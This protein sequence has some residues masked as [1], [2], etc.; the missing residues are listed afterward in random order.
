[1]MIQLL[2][3]QGT[4]L[5]EWRH[6][7][8]DAQLTGRTSLKGNIKT[9]EVLWSHYVGSR[10]TLLEVQFDNSGVKVIDLPDQDIMKYPQFD[11]L[12]K[13]NGI[14]AD[15]D[16]DGIQ[17]QIGSDVGDVLP[18]RPGLERILVESNVNKEGPAIA[19]LYGR[20]NHNWI[21]LWKRPQSPDEN[22]TEGLVAAPIPI[23]GDFDGDGRNEIA[24]QGWYWMYIVDAETGKLKDK[25][26]FII[27]GQAESGRGYGWFGAHDFNGDGK[28]EFVII[29]DT[30]NFVTVM[31]WNDEGK[32]VRLWH[33]LINFDGYKRISVVVPGTNP[34]QDID[35]DG[36]VEIV[37]SVYNYDP[38]TGN[39]D[40]DNKWHIWGIDA[41]TGKT[42]LD[43][44]DH[45]LMGMRDIDG[46]GV[47][48]IFATSA[49][50]NIVPN[51]STLEIY[52]FK[53]SSLVSKWKTGGESFQI[54][55]LN[56]LPLN[57][58]SCA[59]GESL[60][61]LCSPIRSNDNPIFFTRKIIDP[62]S[63]NTQVTAWQAGKDGKINSIGSL[64]APYLEVVSVRQSSDFGVL[65]K[66]QT[67]ESSCQLTAV[68]AKVKAVASALGEVPTSPVAI[69]K[70]DAESN[71]SIVIQGS[72]ET[73]IAFNPYETQN[74]IW[75]RPGRGMATGGSH[76]IG[77]S[78]MGGIVLADV[79]GDGNL[80]TITATIGE[81]GCARLVAYDP[82]G[83][84]I[85]KH[86][87]ADIPGKTP[88]HNIAGLTHWF[89]GRFTDLTHD[90][91]LATPRPKSQEEGYM[92]RG[93]DGAQI[94][95]RNRIPDDNF[96]SRQVGGSW[97]ASFDYDDDGFD[98]LV[99]EYPDM[100][101]VMKGQNGDLLINKGS[102]KIF[103]D[104][105]I[106][107]Y[108]GMP[109]IADFLGDG[110]KQ[111]FW[112]CCDRA[113]GLL[114]KNG[115]V[116][117]EEKRPLP[118]GPGILP[119]IGDIDGDGKLE[120]L[121]L[122]QNDDGQSMFYC[123]DG[124]NGNVKWKFPLPGD[125]FVQG[126]YPTNNTP[127]PPATGDINGDGRDECVFVIGK[128]LYA[129]GITEDG[130]SGGI[131]WQ[132]EFPDS[133]KLGQPSI[134][135]VDGSMNAQIVL[136]GR[137]GYVYGVGNKNDKK[138]NSATD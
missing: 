1:M 93:T 41:V 9:P 126:I 36:V 4:A 135:D 52:S 96:S 132:L 90:D 105:P 112:A 22:W 86:D 45:Y 64:T 44:K 125:T 124:V 55:K 129:A 60:D 75:R 5:G 103:P 20:D 40:T 95:N 50:G 8:G 7:R 42:K 110:T 115:N 118:R 134:A 122:G 136:I 74:I 69:G 121:M 70:L 104:A 3:L 88:V 106:Q 62:I 102:E 21:E 85:W 49:P 6:F 65:M 13:I 120:V 91:I 25:A 2:L 47:S 34:L 67:P 97:M 56:G 18:D 53:G 12:W 99:C 108:N 114:D 54:Q 38:S 27:P 101:Y 10:E 30:Q 68:N 66:V 33:N 87:F 138:R 80:E 123:Y 24:F 82:N 58:N 131:L 59:S 32:L 43:L 98:D 76:A 19:S 29:A 48:E 107:P 79:N 61:I 89:A 119:G 14:W 128:T 83:N 31:G 37:L 39:A 77:H 117:W 111:I 71:S 26:Q 72:G 113:F 137:N 100:L 17:Q 133:I 51:P 109:I 84:L 116:I 81:N 130:K 94:W 57:A 73:I 16:G 23:A 127:L 78:D 28:C 15:L 11:L 35:G 92:L 46:D 63:S